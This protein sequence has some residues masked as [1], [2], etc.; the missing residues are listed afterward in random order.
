MQSRFLKACKT[1]DIRKL[2]TLNYSKIDIHSNYECAFRHA[3]EN[4]HLD[5]VKYLIS[6]EPDHGRIDIHTWDEG[7]FQLACRNGHLDV[8]KYLISLEPEHGRI[9][10]HAYDDYA[11]RCACYDGHLDVVKYLISLEPSHE[12]IDIHARNEWAFRWACYNG[13]LDVVKYLISLEPDHGHIDIHAWDDIAFTKGNFHI[14]QLLIRLDPNYDW[15]NMHEYQKYCEELNQIVDNLSILHQ[16]M[17]QLRTNILEL[18][19]IGIIKEY[20]I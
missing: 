5:V 1:G 13:H 9:D 17:I 3:C 7:A 6:L 14:K 10:I 2:Q 16:K 20:L 18:N 4:G 8:V 19:V 11:F 12:S 15:K